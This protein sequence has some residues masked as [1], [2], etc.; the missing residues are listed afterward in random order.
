MKP[1]LITIFAA[2][3]AHASIIVSV[4]GPPAPILSGTDAGDYLYSYTA[5]LAGD[6]S[7][8]PAA[9]GGASCLGVGGILAECVPSGTFFT[10][11]DTAGLVGVGSAP[12]D[13]IVL[14]QLTGMTPSNICGSCIDDPLIPNIT[15]LYTGPV[16]H[17]DG[18]DT[19]IPGFQIISTLG[20]ITGGV[21]SSQSTLD[22]GPLS[23]D[24]DQVYG[25]VGV[26]GFGISTVQDSPEPSTL[27]MIGAGLLGVVRLRRS[28]R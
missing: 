13:W 20:G 27:L 18:I 15:F 7:L 6:E 5:E 14:V 21:F 3:V 25:G 12:A 11:Y 22:V 23:G 10:I 28:P 1:F 9:T 4:D 24:T 19:P 17:A 8:D 16:V 26:P 2:C